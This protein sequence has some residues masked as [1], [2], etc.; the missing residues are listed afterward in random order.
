MEYSHSGIYRSSCLQVVFKIDVLKNFTIF[1]EKQ[2]CQSL[3][4]IKLQAWRPT[5][6]SKRDSY[7]GVFLWI[8]QNF[9]NSI[10]NRTP[11]M[12]A[13]GFITKFPELWRKSFLSIAFLRNFLEIISVLAT[14]F[15]KITPL[16]VFHS[17][18][19]SLNMSEPYLE[20]SQTSRWSLLQK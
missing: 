17:F 16:Q 12:A 15:L 8:L 5:N 9:K 2:L 20:P 1:T 6:L 7:T 10:F 11:L 4:L 14:V 18:C 13:T 19:L 3:F